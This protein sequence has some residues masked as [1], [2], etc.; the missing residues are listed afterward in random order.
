MMRGIRLLLPA[1]VGNAEPPASGP[2]FKIDRGSVGERIAYVR[3]FSG[4]AAKRS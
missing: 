3:M 4:T 2:V 1:E